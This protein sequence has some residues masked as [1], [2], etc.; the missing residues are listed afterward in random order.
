VALVLL[1]TA[2]LL[3]SRR[4]FHQ[5]ASGMC[6]VHSGGVSGTDCAAACVAAG[7]G[8]VAGSTLGG[9]RVESLTTEVSNSLLRVTVPAWTCPSLSLY[10]QVSTRAKQQWSGVCVCVCEYIGYRNGGQVVCSTGDAVLQKNGV[11]CIALLT[12][13]G[14]GIQAVK[15]H[16]AVSAFWYTKQ[17][18]TPAACGT[19][20]TSRR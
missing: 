18:V 20:T 14:T 8:G 6:G 17:G 12:A 2:A 5:L 11:R 1:E 10:L 19:G 9:P 4:L 3:S 15:L 13:Y 7:A 16:I